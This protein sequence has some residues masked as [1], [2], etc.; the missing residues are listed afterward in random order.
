MQVDNRTHE[1]I[2]N[3]VREMASFVPDLIVK[4]TVAIVGAKAPVVT[5]IG[6]GTLIAVADM[7]FIVT[8]AHVIREAQQRQ[9]TLG[10]AGSGNDSLTALTG[11]CMLSAK[12]EESNKDTQDIA[13]YE[14]DE[15]QV[16]R[17]TG[18]EFLRL[19]DVSFD[20]NLDEFLLVV[21]G[22]PGIWSTQ[23]TKDDEAIKSKILQY[24]TYAF[25]GS[26]AAL[27]GYDPQHHFLMQATPTQLLDHEGAPTSFRTR[28]GYPASFAQ[29]LGGISGCSVWRIGSL[30]TPTEQWSKSNCKLVGV[31][32]GV[33]P[34]RGA[35]KATR[36]KAVASM[37]YHIYPKLR[38]AMDLHPELV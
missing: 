29:D 7:R 18:A 33:F 24:G 31:E 17:L 30:A 27:D 35:I 16:S 20:C 12:S 10:V 37:L 25:S 1:Q 23:S 2:A 9:Y 13:I 6:S 3:S 15:R 34:S 38:P 8:A 22:F 21:T 28:T 4:S 5:Q 11:Q 14:L 36:W 26:T 32:T 19:G